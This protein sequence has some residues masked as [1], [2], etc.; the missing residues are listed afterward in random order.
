M[1]KTIIAVVAA[2][3]LV[4]AACGS[5]SDGAGGEAQS[6]L[7]TMLT[8]ALD[9]AGVVYDEDCISDKASQLSDEDAEAVVVGVLTRGFL[10]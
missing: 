9:E 10:G 2:G 6:E 5:D 7:V 8:D 4:L 3:A 1:N